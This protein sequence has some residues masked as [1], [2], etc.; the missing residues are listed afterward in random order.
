VS[1]IG[2][3]PDYSKRKGAVHQSARR[4]EAALAVDDITCR[5]V[6]ELL[7]EYLEGALAPP[8]KLAVAAHLDGCEGCRRYLEQLN[9]SIV[10][11]AELREDIVPAEVRET[12]LA[13]FRTWR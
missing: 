13:A 2:S 4:S 11:T 5:E 1:R 8:T 7:T 10:A 3:S 6:L 12:L 9:A